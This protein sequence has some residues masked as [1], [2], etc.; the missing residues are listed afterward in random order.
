MRFLLDIKHLFKGLS[1]VVCVLIS[2]SVQ[3]AERVI[4][5][6]VDGLYANAIAILGPSKLPN[7]YRLSAEGASTL[8]ARTDPHFT[9]TLPNHASQFTG[10]SVNAAGGHRWIIN[11]DPGSPVTLHTVAGQYVAGI[12][13]RV[14]DAGKSTSLF[15]GKYKFAVFDRSWNGENGAIDQ[16]GMNHGRDK[17][18]RYVYIRNTDNLVTAFIADLRMTPRHYA[19]LHIRDPDTVGHESGWNWMPN[20]AY[21][22]S[23]IGVDTYLARIISLLE[24]DSKYRGKTALILTSDHGGQ[25]NEIEHSPDVAESHVVP[26]YLWGAGIVAH[27]SLY[28]LNVCRARQPKPEVNPPYVA[29]M[30]PIRNGDAANVAARLLGLPNIT[31]ST[32]NTLRQWRPTFENAKCAGH[33]L[34]LPWV[35]YLLLS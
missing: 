15:A 6:S 1:A 8:A 30:Q 4:H 7:F 13:D 20:S 32:I 25:E 33:L 22:Q 14:H 28:D 29:S 24:T 10:R 34:A 3:A 2:L 12:F 21:M 31:H 16:D 18:D 9:Q 26:F 19:F 27:A 35:N 5:I 23:I 11:F 17:I